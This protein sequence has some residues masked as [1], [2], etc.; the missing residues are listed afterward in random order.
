MINEFFLNR[1]T[2][3]SS[4]STSNE[5]T[6]SD[7]ISAGS[8]LYDQTGNSNEWN[9]VY[10]DVVNTSGNWNSVY[11]STKNTSAN[12]DSVYTTVNSNSSD[13]WD[14]SKSN[15]YTHDNFLPLTGGIVNGTVRIN[16]N[17]TVYGVISAT[18]NSY[19]AN[20]VYST[21]SALSV[22]NIG[23]SGPALYVGN[24]GSGDIASFYDVDEN[25]EVLHVGGNNGSHPNVGIKT[26]EPNKDLTIR[27]ELSASGNIWTSG[28][29]LSAGQN[30]S[31]IIS[32]SSPRFTQD[33]TVSLSNGKTF[34]RY[35]TGQVIPAAGKTPAEVIQLAI[36]ESISP[37]ASLASTST[38]TFNQTAVSNLLNFSYTINTL[39]ASVS[40]A[41]LGWR[42]NNTGSW[43]TLTT[44]TNTP[45]SYTHNYSDTN[46]NTQPFNYRYIVTDT[47]G[48][49]VTVT[50]DITP[51]SYASPGMTLT[52]TASSISSPESNS[53]REK[54]NVASNISG[55]I[56][57]NSTNVPLSSYVIQYQADSG[58]WTD[59][60]TP[61]SISGSSY[62][63]SSFSH[64][65]TANT[66]ASTIAYRIKV[67]DAYQ[68]TTSSTLQTVTFKNIIFYGSSLDTPTNSS[69]VRA[70]T[71]KLFSDGSNPFTLTTGN[72]YTKFTVAMPNTLSITNVIDLDAFNLNITSDYVNNPFSV[73]DIAGNAVSYKVYTKS[74]AVPYT[75][76]VG[77]HRHQ[78]TRG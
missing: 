12:W 30:L 4:V 47:A 40:S 21:T 59:I 62:S 7:Y 14:N 69:G 8:F 39:G 41:S 56:T 37:T 35:S 16:D 76:V 68:T 49:T 31:D 29:I 57:R 74:Q 48:A 55:N 50:K 67:V 72:T 10:T 20:T 75:D 73:N 6:V 19:F 2:F 32:A 9:S 52:L 36:A 3:L 66:G 78:V 46:F 60:G 5:L 51:G 54:G 17:L 18:G 38:I 71:G 27:G 61:T 25:L 70:L 23:N 58:S 13:N 28:N 42:R 53:I 11:T 26:S 63:I 65:P 45:S 22:V 1:V 44:I 64:N 15:E 24:N 34:G 43:T 33:L 77:G